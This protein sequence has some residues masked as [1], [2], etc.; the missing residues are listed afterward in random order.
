MF[1]LAHRSLQK[2]LMNRL[3]TRGAE[4][5]YDFLFLDYYRTFLS[6]GTWPYHTKGFEVSFFSF[7]NIHVFNI[8]PKNSV[9]ASVARTRDSWIA[10]VS[11]SCLCY[12]CIPKH[13][14]LDV[15]VGQTRDQ[16]D[17]E[18]TLECL[19]HVQND[20]VRSI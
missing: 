1:T 4:R 17:L 13:R 10:C 19:N 7:E 16:N 11:N 12:Y 2:M 9:H 18:F 15:N 6:F 20:R 3:C 8:V 5:K 14:M